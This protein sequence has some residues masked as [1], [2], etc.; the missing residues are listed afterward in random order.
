MSSN[1]DFASR[2]PPRKSRPV[3]QTASRHYEGYRAGWHSES[4]P[5]TTDEIHTRGTR[6][7]VD[8]EDIYP[9]RS[10]SSTRR[11]TPVNQGP[12][13]LVVHDQRQKKQQQEPVARRRFHPLFYVGGA[14]SLMLA[15]WLLFSFVGQ[16]WG[17]SQDD[18]HYGY[19]RTFHCDQLVGHGDSETHPT[20]FVAMNI[21]SH[22][23]IVEFPGG[24]T[25]KASIYTGPVLVG[26]S[27]TTN[28]VPVTLTFKD[29][30]GDGKLDMIVNAG[31]KLTILINMGDK[32]RPATTDDHISL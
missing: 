2:V 28:L 27:A 22:I 14:L 13:N 20:H 26:D 7:T 23:V 5:T 12:L 16:W 4:Q 19:P 29:V 17:K 32:F 3:E 6:T 31:G 11:W 10:P 25:D 9:T 18:Q 1:Y 24:R 8:N 21:N 15:G 30:N